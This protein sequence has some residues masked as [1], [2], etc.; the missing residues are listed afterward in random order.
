MEIEE[1]NPSLYFY[2]ENE[3]HQKDESIDNYKYLFKN[4]Y[5]N[6]PTLEE[7]LYQMFTSKGAD[8]KLSKELIERL[9]L[10]VQTIINNNLN[11]IKSQYPNIT[12]ED[13]KIIASYTCEAYKNIY[14][15][16]R[17]TNTNLVEDDRSSG[18]NNVSKYIFLLL[19]S[20]RKLNRYSPD[21][22]GLYRCIKTNVKL[23][24]L[25]NP[26]NS[27]SQGNR[28]TFWGF[29]STTTALNKA[30]NF[31][32][33]KNNQKCG[34]IF[35][36]TGDV[37][38]YDITLFNVYH[39]T[40][41]ILE[42]ERKF[43]I[44]NVIPPNNNDGVTYVSCKIK[45]SKI[46][47]DNNNNFQD[48]FTNIVLNANLKS[49]SINQKK[50]DYQIPNNFNNFPNNNYNNIKNNPIM[51]NNNMNSPNNMNLHNNMNF[52][53]NLN[54]NNNMSLPYYMNFN[55]N[56]NLHNNMNLQSNMN[57]NN[58]KNNSQHN[59]NYNVN[60]NYLNPNPYNNQHNFL[61]DQA[62]YNNLIH[63]IWA[64]PKNSIESASKF[65]I[66]EGYQ[67][68]FF[69]DTPSC[70]QFFKNGNHL[71]M[72]IKCIITSQFR[73]YSRGTGN[74]N[75]F[76]MIDQ[77]KSFLING[78]NPFFVM[79]TLNPDKQQCKDFGFDL[80]VINSRAEMQK[81]VIQ[82]IK[83]NISLYREPFLQPCEQGI[84]ILAEKILSKLNIIR[85]NLDKYIDRCFCKN[86]EPNSISY[87]GDP[88]VKYSLPIGWYRFGIKMDIFYLN[89]NIDTSNWHIGYYGTNLDTAISIIDN[90][91]IMFP[92]EYLNNG[93][94]LPPQD[95]NNPTAIIM[96]PSIK[97]AKLF[98]KSILYG[99]PIYFAFQCR[100]KPGNYE[101][102]R[103][104][105]KN[106]S[107]NNFSYDEIEWV[108][109]KKSSIVPFGFL[110]GF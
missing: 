89:N 87:R 47:L 79:M 97:Y 64:D 78:T 22:R 52:N 8:D 73:E 69:H 26:Y 71:N 55:N 88:K 31:L 66:D 51:N 101:I 25:S 62:N 17:L 35:F 32:G 93:E 40:E 3:C 57:F 83:N 45:N 34:T 67:V 43:I 90:Q 65:F 80:I 85:N 12:E 110:I 99:K 21:K 38:G 1:K 30:K 41:I 49:D 106:Y 74:P 23:F 15:P 24:D 11:E 77:I 96:S 4:Y 29:T 108:V 13:A 63:I 42:P 72:N 6:P 82:R 39:E 98:S 59:M 50:D 54:S 76:Q 33:S 9:L 5:Q 48:N 100:I 91:K 53:N 104:A 84:R 36:L 94:I 20:L 68:H 109:D 27:Y 14:S 7:A 58:L 2:N 46:V 60:N 61:S 37:W 75:A 19:S 56:M 105:S 103:V 16:Y 102:N 18:V 70:I 86:C 95:N 44:E 92:G 28:K 107:D 10:K 81:L